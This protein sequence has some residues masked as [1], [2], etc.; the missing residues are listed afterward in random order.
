MRSSSVT[1]ISL[2]MLLVASASS[3]AQDHVYNLNGTLADAFGGPSLSTLGGSLAASGFTFGFNEGL[4]LTG[5]VGSTYTIAMRFRFDEVSGYRRI[6]DFK[7][8]ASDNGPYVLSGA[9]NFY[10]T[11]TG[12]TAPYVP[13]TLGLTIFTR[14]AAG[15]FSA[16]FGGALQYS[17]LD[18]GN[19]GV[20]SVN[21]VRFFQDDLSVGNEAS[22][23]FVN[24]IAT[25]NSALTQ[26]QVAAFVPGTPT[27]TVPEPATFVLLGAGMLMAG[28]V[29][30]CKRTT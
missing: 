30:R 7:D 3:Q 22:A 13:N 20:R 28:L 17:F 11:V 27:T 9:S 19:E 2:G 12:P 18:A 14:D 10:P 21:T 25:W 29:Q 4:S 1:A 5:V 16:Y 6:I 23:G 8:R 24:Y 26:A 15:L